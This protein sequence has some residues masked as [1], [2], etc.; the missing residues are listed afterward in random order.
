M[1][2]FA[3]FRH[4]RFKYVQYQE[5]GLPVLLFGDLNF[6]NS[7]NFVRAD[8]SLQRIDPSAVR[9]QRSHPGRRVQ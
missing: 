1:S 6:A 2:L 8:W 7:D 9:L 5:D 4:W 3:A